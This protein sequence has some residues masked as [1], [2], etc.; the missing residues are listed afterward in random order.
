[1]KT[2]V[3]IGFIISL[4]AVTPIRI[5]NI[6]LELPEGFE[7][8]KKSDII[9]ENNITYFKAVGLEQEDV[10]EFKIMPKVDDITIESAKREVIEKYKPETDYGIENFKTPF[11][12]GHIA[13]VHNTSGTTL[14]QVA[15]LR[16]NLNAYHIVL[17]QMYKS[18]Q[19][20]SK[21][22]KKFLSSVQK[23]PT[24]TIGQNN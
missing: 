14:T 9:K 16:N 20:G 21:E 1:M 5:N 17:R 10:L 7:I 22:F 15:V 12:K 13:A 3:T 24:K 8:P 2:L 23:V 11:F 18:K 6:I 4:F 19:Q